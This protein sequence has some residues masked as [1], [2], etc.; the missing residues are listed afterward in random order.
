[1]DVCNRSHHGSRM[2]PELLPLRATRDCAPPDVAR[3]EEQVLARM[4]R[5]RDPCSVRAS[6]PGRGHRTLD[7]DT[8]SLDRERYMLT[9]KFPTERRV[10]HRTISVFAL[11]LDVSG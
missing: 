9:P 1:M 7:T 4:G 11:H 3:L 6:V 10:P 8:C 5:Q 2:G